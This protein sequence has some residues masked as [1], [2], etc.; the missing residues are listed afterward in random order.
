MGGFA[1]DPMGPMSGLMGRLA[2]KVFSVWAVKKWGDPVGSPTSGQ[3]GGAWSFKNY[4]YSMLSGYLGGELV[5]RMI[6]KKA[7]EDFYRGSADFTATKLMWSQLVMNWDWSKQ[8]LGSAYPS[9]A[10]SAYPSFGTAE[11]RALMAQGTPGDI[12]DDG[13]GNR[14]L[15][16]PDGRWI[17]MMGADL[18][19]DIVEAG[20]LGA[21][22]VEA[23][24]LGGPIV[25]AGPLG[26][27]MNSQTS[28]A[29]SAMAA[30][31]YRG[32]RDPF[33]AAFM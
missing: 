7:G 4:L 11:A 32:S 16:K 10:G 3:T 23:G 30:Y 19:A 13:Q 14:L 17:P 29:D 28:D 21:D 31:T 8:A 22:I 15:M 2:G 1:L 20:P 5:S 9:F 24:P 12:F 6:G 18:G 25:E 26:H 27:M 33:Q